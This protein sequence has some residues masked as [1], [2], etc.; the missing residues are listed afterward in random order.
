MGRAWSFFIIIMI[1][2]SLLVCANAVG[3]SKEE[4][5]H[6]AIAELEKY[7]NDE[8]GV[9]LYAIHNVFSELG[10]YEF[11]TA[12][13][14]YTDI[15]LQ[16]EDNNYTNTALWL[17]QIKRNSAFDTF[18]QESSYGTLEEFESYVHGR[19]AEYNKD[20][21]TAITYYE[22]SISFMDSMERIFSL[23]ESVLE[24]KYQEGL[25]LY[26]QGTSDA[27]AAAHII[28]TE[29]AAVRYKDS[30][31]LAKE[32]IAYSTIPT[33]AP[34][35]SGPDDPRPSPW[36][37]IEF[38]SHPVRLMSS[39]ERVYARLGP[40]RQAAIVGGYKVAKA[41]EYTA[42][43]REGDYIY[44]DAIYAG[45][46]RRCAYFPAGSVTYSKQI[47]TVVFEKINVTLNKTVCPYLGP[48]HEYE[49]FDKVVL[50]EGTSIDVCGQYGDWVF[51]EFQYAYMDGEAMF[52][53]TGRGWLESVHIAP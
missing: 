3:L 41:A 49:H 29:L 53:G 5:Y 43:F 4:R 10:S 38:Q 8:D 47:E 35:V 40:D 46:D 21:S 45:I 51:V 15:L 19:E 22:A 42:L 14:I 9:S 50:E 25:L 16:I 37:V 32:T 12:F 13:S 30:V 11:S 1:C 2:I 24:Q 6:S 34:V 44:C 31:N 52:E 18:L 33:A 28:F 23:E 26:N 7:L 27:Y 20:I 36:P 39:S 48:A 17:R